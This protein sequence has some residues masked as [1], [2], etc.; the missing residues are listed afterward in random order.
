MIMAYIRILWV[1]VNGNG[2]VVIIVM[3]LYTIASNNNHISISVSLVYTTL[4]YQY[5]I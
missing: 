4:L 3:W 5:I 1:I 2:H